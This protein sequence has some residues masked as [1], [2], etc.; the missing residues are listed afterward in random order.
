MSHELRTPLNAILGFAEVMNRD[1]SLT[2]EQQKHL[3][4]I[5]RSG[6]HLLALIND[7]LEMSK[8]EA[9]RITYN[10]SSFDLN[11]LLNTLEDMLRIRAN[12]KGLELVFERD[13]DVPYYIRSDENKLR[14]VLINLLGNAI[15]FTAVGGVTLHVGFDKKTQTTFQNDRPTNTLYFEVEDTGVGI[16][17][18]DID[19]VFQPFIQTAIGYKSTEG[20]GLGLSISRKFVQL[21]GGEMTVGSQPNRGSIFAFNLPITSA[22]L[23]EIESK[24]SPRIIGLAPEQPRYR[25]LI[26]ED[27]WTNRQLLVKLLTEIGFEVQEAKDGRE[28]VERWESWQPHLILMD[29]RMPVMD[30]YEATKEI[31]ARG[32]FVAG[33]QRG[34]GAEGQVCSRGAGEHQSIQ[35]P[36]SK[37]PMPHA[38]CPMPHAQYP[39]PKIIALSASTFS[40][41][42]ADILAVGC[43]D[44]I[45]KPF[46][47]DQLLETL[48]RHLGVRYVYEEPNRQDS[49]NLPA[50]KQESPVPGEHP[51]A[52]YLSQMPA[53]WVK[54][55]Y[56][57]ALIGDDELM[58][59]H[60][61]EIPATCAPLRRAMTDWANEYRF[62]KVTNFIESVNGWH[63]P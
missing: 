13:P 1:P 52:F 22:A 32:R 42:R 2:P 51:L 34:R 33:E 6:E 35:N 49:T 47:E 26:A 38:P 37:I 19:R 25:L 10:E 9:G 16:A 48:A 62:D 57:A 12:A 46:R 61:A 15:K 21:M 43:D 7:V 41:E 31:R 8:I 24:P 59:E 3:D 45:G 63:S 40:E 4:I 14:Q 50:A 5:N 36:K 17:P 23:D 54:Q 58:F 20:T 60:M 55:F 30:G 11:C 28:A 44:F 18:E 39:I 53:E 29:V 27:K 56:E